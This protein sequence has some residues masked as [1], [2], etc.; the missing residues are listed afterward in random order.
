[1]Q[2]ECA[3]VRYPAFRTDLCCFQFS[4]DIALHAYQ[5]LFVVHYPLTFDRDGV[6]QVYV[7]KS[8]HMMV[9]L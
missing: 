9:T 4:G 6:D 3:S 8:G 7:S 1:M 5:D 2:V